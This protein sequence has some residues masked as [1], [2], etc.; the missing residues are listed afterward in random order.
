MP[1]HSQLLAFRLPWP[2][3]MCEVP[4]K[5]SREHNFTRIGAMMNSFI[6]DIGPS[7]TLA[8][9]I[10]KKIPLKMVCATYFHAEP[11]C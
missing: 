8:N 6:V 9:H 7:K 1:Q 5:R 11:G 10:G 2:R 3:L 4:G